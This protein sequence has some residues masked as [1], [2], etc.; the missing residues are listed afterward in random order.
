MKM[1]H[2]S[3]KS[4]E[5]QARYA[6]KKAGLIAKK[7]RRQDP[8][9]NEGGFQLTDSYNTLVAGA[10]FSLSSEAVINYCRS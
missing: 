8:L 4:L 1:K 9:N 6:A 10:C 5:T 7:S 2:I 3:K